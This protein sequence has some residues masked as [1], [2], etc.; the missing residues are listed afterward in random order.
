MKFPMSQLKLMLRRIGLNVCS[1]D[2]LGVDVEVD[3]KRLET[4]ES[5]KTIFDVGGN[6]GQS[7]LK[8][9]RAFPH[10]T[11]LSFEPVPD[12]FHQLETRTAKTPNV[13]AFNF[14]FGDAPGRFQIQIQPDSQGNSL[15][16]KSSGGSA[17]EVRLETVDAFAAENDIKPIDLLKIDVEGF[18]LQVLQGASGMLRDGA[19]RHVFA[20]CVFAPD[21]I[22][23]HTDFFEL[24]RVLSEFGLCIVAFY[25]ESLRLADGCALGNVL[26]S[27]KSRLPSRAAGKIRNIY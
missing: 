9:S 21:E 16:S 1:A 11:V 12:S 23:P 18:E 4:E 7:A 3:L 10:A 19:V 20:E 2:R 15:S 8:F 5:F 17:V 27:L 24:N 26:F 25:G 6:F 14:G 13:Q 22:H